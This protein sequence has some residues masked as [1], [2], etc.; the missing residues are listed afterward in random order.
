MFS[1][2]FFDWNQSIDSPA[3]WFTMIDI[4]FGG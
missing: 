3:N 1:V 2:G 4:S